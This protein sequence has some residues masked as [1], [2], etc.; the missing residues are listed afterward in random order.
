MEIA[1]KIGEKYLHEIRSSFTSGTIGKTMSDASKEFYTSSEK[2]SFSSRE[3]KDKVGEI[4]EAMKYGDIQK[5]NINIE[6]ID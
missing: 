2:K 3:A 1:I 6:I 5:N 4:I